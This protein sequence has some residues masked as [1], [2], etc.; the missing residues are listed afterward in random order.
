MVI[1]Q[2]FERSTLRRL[3]IDT[4]ASLNTNKPIILFG[5]DNDSA[6]EDGRN[7]TNEAGPIS[8]SPF[9]VQASSRAHYYF[10]NHTPDKK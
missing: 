10:N 4:G 5:H 6:T 9:R 3:G 7:E 8:G 2:A 1:G